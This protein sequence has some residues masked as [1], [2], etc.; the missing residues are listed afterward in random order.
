MEVKERMK[1]REERKKEPQGE[2]GLD[3]REVPVRS[4][5][6]SEVGIVLGHRDRKLIL[7]RNCS[8][9]ASREMQSCIALARAYKLVC[10]SSL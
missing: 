7:G 3:C 2:S 5:L 4:Q 8:W 10:P 9:G 6:C 1:K